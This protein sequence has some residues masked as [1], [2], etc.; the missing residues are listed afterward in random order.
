[1]RRF[2]KR[3][4]RRFTADGNDGRQYTIYIY[5]DLIDAGSFE[6]PNTVAEGFKELRTSD[7]MVVNLLQEGVYQ[8]VQTGVVLRSS[9]PD[10]P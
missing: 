1:M 8:I 5:T 6:D 3:K 7:G 10:A 9:S 2:M 4:T